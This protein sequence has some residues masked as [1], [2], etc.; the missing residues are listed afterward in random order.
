MAV[1]AVYRRHDVEL[2]SFI[3][4]SRAYMPH[5]L[6]FVLMIHGPLIPPCPPPTHAHVMHPPPPSWHALLVQVL[7][8]S[9]SEL[10]ATGG[11]AEVYKGMSH[12][13]GEIIVVKQ[14]ARGFTDADILVMEADVA[15]LKELSHPNIV[16]YLGTDMGQ[17]LSILLEYVPGGS[18]ASLL[19]QYGVLEDDVAQ[20]YTRQALYGL[21][22][23]HTKVW[24]PPPPLSARCS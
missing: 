15:I 24:D 19:D 5:A 13:T 9:T 8:Y 22:Y 1:P 6:M 23:L 10:L 3:M 2:E 14:L 4:N 7:R 16:R 20:S 11:F 17:H 21:S 18:I 12:D